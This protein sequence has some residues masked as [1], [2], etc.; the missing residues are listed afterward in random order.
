MSALV[1]GLSVLGVV[2]ASAAGLGE[3]AAKTLGADVA[4][5]ASCETNGVALKYNN[6]HNDSLDR[7][8]TTSVVVSGLDSSC[9]GKRVSVTLSGAGGV[10]LRSGTVASLVSTSVTV[11]L[12]SPGAD[13][14]QVVGAAVVIT[15]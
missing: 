5:V 10:S 6:K 12:T 8:Q 7:Y 9:F 15:G 11:S 3:V 4:V 2:G 14:S 13:T 1:A